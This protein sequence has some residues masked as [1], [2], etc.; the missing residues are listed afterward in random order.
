MT[1]PDR[2]LRP[3]QEARPAIERLE[4]YESPAALQEALR[5]TWHAVDRSLRLLLRGEASAPDEVRLAAL[6]PAELPLDAVLT[7][8]RR[9][10]RI[11]LG[12]AGR[13]HELGQAVRRSESGQPRATDADHALD[14]VHALELEL[15]GT[16]SV[17]RREPAVSTHGAAVRG[18]AGAES[19]HDEAGA[20]AAAPTQTAP[21]AEAGSER[22]GG[23]AAWLRGVSRRRRL[24]LGGAAAA[25]LV[26]VVLLVVLLPGRG[27]ELARGVAAFREGRSGQAEQHF[28]TVLRR[29]REHVTA[30][31]YL[32]RILRDQG[33]HQEA[34][35]L[36]R[37]AAGTAP[38]DAAVRRELGYLLLDLQRP[39]AAVEQFRM[40]VE[41]EP[42]EPL[43]WVWL[44]QALY[45]ADD[46]SADE[47]LRRAPAPVRAMVEARRR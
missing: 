5:A 22:R 21:V 13:V 45:R 27:G 42:D 20:G 47:W 3:L 43:G 38:R 19:A 44:V 7:E 16:S 29:D 2:A 28:R 12:L 30:R 34:A 41:L 17:A 9:R 14:V 31:L 40:A 46:P 39:D 15:Q 4:T 25:L 10:D 35:Q 18:G 24:W 6:S 8:L 36:L 1:E 26:A 37:E 23:V 32:A 11:S 33:R